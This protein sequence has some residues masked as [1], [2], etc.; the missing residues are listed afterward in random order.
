MII[1]AV[2]V[3]VYLDAVILIS[4]DEADIGGK[5]KLS[6]RQDIQI[7]RRRKTNQIEIT[8]VERVRFKK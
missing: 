8:E 6:W 4:T 1:C 7:R 2:F 5:R 3:T